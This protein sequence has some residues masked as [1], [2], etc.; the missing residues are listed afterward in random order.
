MVVVCISAATVFVAGQERPKESSARKAFLQRLRADSAKQTA[1]AD[2]LLSVTDV[3]EPDSFGKNVKFL[4]TA[5]TGIIRIRP[6]CVAVTLGP[7]DRRIEVNP[8]DLSGSATG[9]FLNLGRI[10]IPGRSV[11]NVV[12]FIPNNE[13]AVSSLNTSAIPS[14]G[15]AGYFPYI[16][17][18][19]DALNDP[20]AIDPG[21][22]LP[23]NGSLTLGILGTRSTTRLF[24]P[25]EQNIDQI[26]YSTAATRGFARSYFADLG[27]P[28]NVI[29]RLY[30][31]PMTIK[32]NLFVETNYV[33]TGF[34]RYSVRFMGN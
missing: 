17:I 12:Y 18:E 8:A 19:S 23:A 11:G 33:R 3:G 25:A 2:G 20:A 28:Q 34:F 24:Q 30:R 14:Y 31:L 6:N 1:S 16:T 4:G 5:R 32:L 13:V 10:T 21:T 9:D 26:E 7:D 22:G 27:L 15:Y 29:D